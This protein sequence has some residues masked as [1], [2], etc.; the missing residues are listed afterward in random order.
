MIVDRALGLFLKAVS[1]VLA[2]YVIWWED[3]ELNQSVITGD[4]LFLK[5]LCSLLLHVKWIINE[6]RTFWSLIFCIVF[7]ILCFERNTV[8]YKNKKMLFEVFEI[9]IFNELYVTDLFCETCCKSKLFMIWLSA[10]KNHNC[11]LVQFG[12]W[13]YP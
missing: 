10:L 7:S 11:F 1:P 13:I 3:E 5:P 8:F 4:L 2:S 9:N 12:Y 6:T